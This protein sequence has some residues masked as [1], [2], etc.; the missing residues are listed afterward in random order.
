MTFDQLKGLDLNDLLHGMGLETRRT[1]MDSLVPAVALFGV[2]ML[3]GTGLG[4]LM[5]PSSGKALRKDIARRLDDVPDA[6]GRLPHQANVAMHH[7]ADQLAD[8]IHDA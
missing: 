8:K 1:A 6:L 4:M 5:A 2:G 7:A 3:V